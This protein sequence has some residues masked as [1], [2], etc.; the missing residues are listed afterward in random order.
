MLF[1]IAFLFLKDTTRATSN[2]RL[3][4]F[5][6]LGAAYLTRPILVLTLVRCVLDFRMGVF[7]FIP[8][9]LVNVVGFDGQTSAGLYMILYIGSI[10]GTVSFGIISDRVNKKYVVISTLIFSACFVCILPYLN[11]IYWIAIL[12]LILGFT[13]QTVSPLLQ[14]LVT[15]FTEP[16]EIDRVYGIY[17]TIAFTMGL[18]GPLVFGSIADAYNFTAA[19]TYV[20]IVSLTAAIA[21]I[22][23][24]KR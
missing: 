17:Y 23:I 13:Y 22:F 1:G 11:S 7:S 16:E 2:R 6:G 20:S 19:F 3:S 18:V 4:F 8:I 21:A 14:A 9:Y 10:I 5:R 15:D 12:L 24:P